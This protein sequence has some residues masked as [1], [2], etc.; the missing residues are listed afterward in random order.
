MFTCEKKK[1][2]KMILILNSPCLLLERPLI[3][4][5]QSVPHTTLHISLSI[6]KAYLIKIQPE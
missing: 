4:K 6:D 2:E 3:S 1:N 5:C